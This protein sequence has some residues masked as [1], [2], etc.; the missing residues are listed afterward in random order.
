MEKP[1]RHF[2]F[3][4]DP[5]CLWVVKR[6]DNGWSG[7][8]KRNIIFPRYPAR[9]PWG[10]AKKNYKMYFPDRKFDEKVRPTKRPLSL[11]LQN[12]KLE[13]SQKR[14][15]R[16]KGGNM[17]CLCVGKKGSFLE[18]SLAPL[19]VSSTKWCISCSHQ[20]KLEKAWR[21]LFILLLWY[22]LCLTIQIKNIIYQIRIT[23]TPTP[24]SSSPPRIISNTELW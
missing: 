12:Q 24:T 19:C 11:M 17:R 22:L 3:E 2:I 13:T 6:P 21:P 23:P 5:D 8:T 4:D 9:P 16:A 20:K 10:K 7:S 1:L 15:V 14:C 18:R